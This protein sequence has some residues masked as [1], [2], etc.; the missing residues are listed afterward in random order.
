MTTK[1]IF[2]ALTTLL[3]AACGGSS[4]DETGGSAD[5]ALQG[6][7]IVSGAVESTA[8]GLVVNGITFQTSGARITTDDTT[9]PIALNGEDHFRSYVHEGMIVRIRG[10]R[11][12]SSGRAEEIEL[13]DL[14]EGNVEDR[15][16]GRVRV[17]GVDVSVDDSTVFEDNHGGRLTPDDF[18]SGERIEISGHADGRGGV[19]ATSVRKSSD[20]TEIEREVRAWVVA[21]NGSVL[22]LSFEKGGA[23]ALSVDVSGV[24]PAPSISVGDFVEVKT[25]GETNAAGIPLATEIHR[26]DDSSAG[27]NIQAEIEGIVSAADSSG[28]T[29]AGQRV[30]YTPST[31]FIGGTIDD[32]VVGVKVEAE[33][34]LGAD[35]ALTA[36][37]VKFRPVVRIDANVETVDA[38]ASSLSLL[39]LTV[40]VTP[41]TDLRGFSGLDIP[42][43]ARIEVRGSPTRDGSAIDAVR[44]ELI[45]T[46]SNDR[47]FVRGVVTEKSATSQLK[48]LG[49]TIDTSRASFRNHA[50]A[51]I[52]A[53]AFFDAVT[54]GA[55][56]VK[57]R[58]RPY[59]TS[60]AAAVDEAELEND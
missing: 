13:H 3:L 9:A 53:S 45:D 28:F 19:R 36:F 32:V 12:D 60:T 5:A 27:A 37:K 16:P 23:V 6:E 38:A 2:F 42:T 24:V 56:V 8:G 29:I 50:D 54:P 14:L 17:S 58:W 31:R 30:L 57:V 25:R 11:D 51:E 10:S 21:A 43:G 18:S 4:S 47:A 52:G 55:T 44:I 48:M 35:G 49:L 15:G 22:D 1:R 59:P 33:G 41:S 20:A 34:A 26:E 46:S 7:A 40:H 39:G